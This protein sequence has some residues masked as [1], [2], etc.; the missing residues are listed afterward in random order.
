MEQLP[1]SKRA[2][3]IRSLLQGNSILSIR[4]TGTS[5]DD[6]FE[7][8]TKTGRACSEYQDRVLRDPPCKLIHLNEIWAFMHAKQTTCRNARSAP[9]GA[10][11][12]WTWTAI[13]ADTKLVP[14]WL[15]GARDGEY[16]TAFVEDLRQR[17]ANPVVLV[18]DGYRAHLCAGNDAEYTVLQQ[19]YGSPFE[20]DQRYSPAPCIGSGRKT[21]NGSPDSNHVSTSYIQRQNLMMRITRR[22]STELMKKKFT[23]RVV[24]YEAALALHFMHHNFVRMDRTSCVTP[25]MAAGVT[26]RPWS[27]ED[28][29]AL[30]PDFACSAAKRPS[31]ARASRSMVS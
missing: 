13:C 4:M 30:A 8:L 11:E 12:V 7:Q 28:I 25:A 1:S 29:V 6:I 15:V 2:E 27:V 18:S 20:T 31:Q 21:L 22:P 17:L 10:G 14:S 9:E 5:Y 19:L 23:D 3:I 24:S 26:D 16:A